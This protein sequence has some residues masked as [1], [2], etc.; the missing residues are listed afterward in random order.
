[1]KTGIINTLVISINNAN[2]TNTANKLIKNK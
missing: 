1:M 2:K